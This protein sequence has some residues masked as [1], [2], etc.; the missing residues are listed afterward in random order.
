MKEPERPLD[1]PERTEMTEEEYYAAKEA[2]MDE[3]RFDYQM[4]EKEDI[5]DAVIT[6]W[7]DVYLAWRQGNAQ[8]AISRAM[9]VDVE[10]RLEAAWEE[11]GG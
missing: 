5:L 6:A 1:P 3:R 4:M 10:R 2:F 8:Y 11:E 9:H 7:D